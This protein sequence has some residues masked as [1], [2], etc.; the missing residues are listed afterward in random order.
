MNV[1]GTAKCIEQTFDNTYHLN[2]ALSSLAA[3]AK[4]QHNHPGGSCFLLQ[5]KW[6]VFRG[7]H[8]PPDSTC[9]LLVFLTLDGDVVTVVK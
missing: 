7:D 3:K 5:G 8:Y 4:R 6:G 2:L 9:I 1:T